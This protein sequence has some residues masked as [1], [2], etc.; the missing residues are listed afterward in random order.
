MM[1]IVIKG[2]LAMCFPI[3]VD[4]IHQFLGIMFRSN[5]D[6]LLHL[7]FG[8]GIGLDVGSVY[9]N[10][11]WRKI[12]DLCHLVQDPREYLCYGFFGKTMPEVIADG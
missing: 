10:C 1:I 7:L 9:E 6:F 12:P 11:L 2:F 8:V 5:R 3:C 4:L